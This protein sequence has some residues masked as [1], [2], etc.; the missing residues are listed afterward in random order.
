MTAME[1]VHHATLIEADSL[2]ASGLVDT[3]T[4]TSPDVAIIEA[5]RLSIAQAKEVIATAWQRPVAAPT[6]TVV[7]V[8]AHIATEAQHALLKILE[9]PPNTA[10]FILVL[11][12]T[13]N[14]LPTLIS[15]LDRATPR[16]EAAASEEFAAFC[17]E[18][19]PERLAQIAAKAKAKDTQWMV[20]V[21]DGLSVHLLQRQF[22]RS[23][24]RFALTAAEF[25]GLA[26]ASKKMLLE[27]LALSL[28]VEKS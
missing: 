17:R 6:R 28:P 15:R 3:L 23:T 20:R 27:G 9:D 13:D 10:R 7:I 1:P 5:D 21:I 11:S 2:D 8:A 14:L 26:G 22:D 4:R 24:L 18:S 19:V 16:A 12:R 25:A